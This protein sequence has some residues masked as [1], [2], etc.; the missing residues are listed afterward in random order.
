MTMR[1]NE[2]FTIEYGQ[3]EY[4]SKGHLAGK[5]G[6]IPL[7]SSSATSHGV[8]GFFDIK[9]KYKNVISIAST[10]SV[11]Y[12]FYHGYDCCIDDNCLV[13][14]PIKPLTAEE[15]IYFAYL[16]TKN[17]FRFMYGRQA[18]PKRLGEIIIPDKI[19]DWVYQHPVKNNNAS[20]RPANLNKTPSL[21]SKKWEWFKYNELFE[22]KKGKRLT[23]QDM[24]PG[25]TRFIGSSDSNNGITATIG[26]EPIHSGNTISVCYN[27]S[28]AEA[29]YQP[30]PFWATDD[31]NV[32]YPKFELSPFIALFLTTL[33]R[34]EKYRYNYGRKWHLGRMGESEIKL[35]VDGNGKPDW[36]WIEQYIKSLQYSSVVS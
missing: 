1:I 34:K 10:G 27:G 30:K 23:K 29:F 35:P 26:Q 13:A 3:H 12:A 31:V 16:I 32:L 20:L 4:H 19:P 25:N 33:I 28:V 7:I 8:F 5:D 18:T 14:K 6:A 11:G 17:R 15:M 9:P 22:I 24:T 36:Q 2:F 21:E